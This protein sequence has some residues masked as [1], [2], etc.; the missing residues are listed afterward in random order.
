MIAQ[1]CE[2]PVTTCDAFGDS[3]MVFPRGLEGYAS[4]ATSVIVAVLVK[5]T[6]D[7]SWKF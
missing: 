7:P 2:L 3:C 1:V 4:N 6:P 5:D